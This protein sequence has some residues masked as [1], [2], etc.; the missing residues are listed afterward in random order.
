MILSATLFS[1]SS[2]FESE[3]AD[4]KTIFVEVAMKNIVIL[5]VI[6]TCAI[7]TQAALL[8]YESFG[9]ALNNA[10][11]QG[12]AGTS[13][14]SG[15]SGVWQVTGDQ[16]TGD[17]ANTQTATPP[18]WGAQI[19]I[20]HG[21]SP[22][23][24]GG[25]QHV[26]RKTAWSTATASRPLVNPIDLTSD[27][28]Y[29]MSFFAA[30]D[31]ADFVAQVG[32][33]NDTHEIMAGN[34]WNWGGLTAY[35]GTLGTAPTTNQ[36]GTTIGGTWGVGDRNAF[37][38]VKFVKS[39]SSSTND[40]TV[41][42]EFYD[43]GS[44]DPADIMREPNRYRT[45]SLTGVSGVFTNLSLKVA[46]W[47]NI[48]EIRLGESFVDVVGF[49]PLP[50]PDPIIGWIGDLT[51]KI[52]NRSFEE[53]DLRV[54]DNW[55]LIP[56]WTSRSNPPQDS[57]T[58]SGGA[59]GTAW[60]GYVGVSDE[61]AYQIVDVNILP[62]IP[63]VL[64]AQMRSSY[65]CESGKIG[66]FYL[67]DEPN[68]NSQWIILAE[69]EQTGLTGSYVTVT[70][71]F[72][73]GPDDPAVGKKLG[74]FFDVTDTDGYGFVGCDEFR[75][76]QEAIHGVLDNQ[77]DGSVLLTPQAPLELT[78]TPS[79]DP[80]VQQ[81]ILYYY[82][83]TYDT[84]AY[85]AVAGIPLSPSTAS[86][87]IPSGISY[88][89]YLFWRVDTIIDTNLYTGRTYVVQAEPSDF[90]PIV[91][92]GYNYITWLS[93]LPQLLTG[94]V[95]DLGEGDVADTDVVWSIV[96]GPSGASASVVKTSADP[97][98]PTA[99]FTTDRAG[100]YVIKL[101]ATDTNGGQGPQSASDTLTVRVAAD[102]CA[103]QQMVQSGYNA[104]DLNQDCVVNLE[105][106]AFLTGQWLEDI[107]LTVAIPY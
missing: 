74:I 28:T 14:E 22:E 100:D 79:N 19:G 71:S 17:A 94:T 24:V 39:N 98:N 48:D 68:I 31:G 3:S 83:G 27:G 59:N 38:V 85:L 93:N 95:D 66:M 69:Q 92:A 82:I 84:T 54:T 45:L 87:T 77:P 11:L 103:A 20:L 29:Y 105:D 44:E 65:S 107:R 88:D 58:Q 12:Y 67:E 15:L 72:M 9:D 2:L 61:P 1:V 52:V 104:A 55:D 8:A 60:H 36:N 5:L 56:G 70:T 101:T 81:Q 63:Y 43:L 50:V 90:P 7:S 46:G 62:N 91:E 75:L 86:Y 4:K 21:Y 41:T 47:P 102:A 10:L 30:C 32:L 34:V 73:V 42:V 96:S 6:C 40:L 23:V 25:A 53:P 13:A 106:L 35:Y 26:V 49:V 99:S 89:Q 16:V 51:D 97:L 78:W 76:Y 57:G 37:F 64:E 80:N 33:A 18:T